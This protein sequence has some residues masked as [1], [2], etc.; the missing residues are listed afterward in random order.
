VTA[1][2]VVRADEPSGARENTALRRTLERLT[3]GTHKRGR[4][5]VF[6]PHESDALYEVLCSRTFSQAQLGEIE[7]A[8]REMDP[9]ELDS[10]WNG[11]RLRSFVRAARHRVSRPEWI[12]LPIARLHAA[13]RRQGR[14]KQFRL[15]LLRAALVTFLTTPEPNRNRLAG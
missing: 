2:R 3:Y 6:L 15:W 12:D 8:L 14:D 7:A 5:F 10:S 1:L 11:R 9:H 13:M 4:G